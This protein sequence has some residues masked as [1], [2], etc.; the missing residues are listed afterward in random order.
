MPESHSG[1]LAKQ[2]HSDTTPESCWG[3]RK[4]SGGVSA[5]FTDTRK[6]GCHG[7][8]V[9]D[10][11][12]STTSSTSHSY[13]VQCGTIPQFLDREALLPIG[14]CLV[15]LRV[16]IFSLGATLNYSIISN[17]LT[18]RLLWLIIPLSGRR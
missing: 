8:G 1:S 2:S 17:G 3:C 18:F 12:Q 10:V 16:S 9:P 7:E 13:I 14:V 4:S 15:W 11:L 6:K 5:S